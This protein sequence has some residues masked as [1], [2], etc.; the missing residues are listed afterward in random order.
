[1]GVKGELSNNCASWGLAFI[2]LRGKLSRLCAAYQNRRGQ[3]LFWGGGWLGGTPATQPFPREAVGSAPA[4]PEE[5]D[6]LL[7][8][9]GISRPSLSG[10]GD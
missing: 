1:M 4:L 8:G 7:E 9:S 6:S 5:G 2:M 3:A 10:A